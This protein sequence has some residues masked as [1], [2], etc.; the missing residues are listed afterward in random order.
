[1]KI[2][3]ASSFDRFLINYA[4]AVDDIDMYTAPI[5]TLALW[6]ND[7]KYRKLGIGLALAEFAVKTPFVIMYVAR[8]MDYTSAVEW[9]GW[10]TLAH[11]IPYEGGLLSIRRNYEKNARTFIENKEAMRRDKREKYFRE[12]LRQEFGL[13]KNL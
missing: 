7:P 5:S 3:C 4:R 8:T 10:E 12:K 6:H 2:N 1:M 13:D 11:A 9:L